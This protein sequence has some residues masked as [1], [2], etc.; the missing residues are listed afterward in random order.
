MRFRT[1]M[2]A[3]LVA[4]ASTQAS[5]AADAAYD[6][7]FGDLI[8]HDFDGKAIWEL[9]AMCA[10]YHRA[11]AAYWT[12]EGRR[13]RARAAQVASAQATNRVVD[14]LSRDRGLTDRNEA[15]RLAAASEQVG[16]RVTQAALAKDRT[17]VDGQWNFWRTACMQADR[18]F[19]AARGGIEQ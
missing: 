12:A 2:L 11:T 9:Q 18:A 19:F 15:I 16:V 8:L 4:L 1:V 10:G 7:R 6:R 14:Q 17:S 13:D 5:S 3:G